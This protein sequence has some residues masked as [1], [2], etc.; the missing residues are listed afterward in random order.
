VQGNFLE[1]VKV[2]STVV[3]RTRAEEV[4]S[5]YLDFAIGT[6]AVNHFQDIYFKG[7]STPTANHF[8]EAAQLIGDVGITCGARLLGRVAPK[9]SRFV[10][11]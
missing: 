6:S 7:L 10:S 5:Y 4:L 9:Y 2:W 1:Y 11:A 8:K 3:N